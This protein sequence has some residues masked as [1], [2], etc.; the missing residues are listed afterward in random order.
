MIVRPRP[1]AHQLIYIVRGSVVRRIA[2]KVLLIAALSTAVV[3]FYQSNNLQFLNAGLG[4]FSILGLALSVFLGFRNNAC[5]DRWWEA[6][7][8]WGDLIVHSRSFARE[9]AALYPQ[10]ELRQAM[11]RRMIAYAHA[12]AAR[13][14]D[15]SEADAARPWLLPA[16]HA[17]LTHAR[18]VPNALLCM[19][20]D[21]LA[22]LYRQHQLS[23]I[24]YQTF[25]NKLAA[26]AVIQGACERIKTTPTPFA[27]SLLLRR[28]AWLFCLLLP[29]SLA[30]SL[31]MLAPLIVAAIAYTFFGLDYLGDELEEPFGLMDNDLPLNALVRGIEVDMLESLG[32]K[33]LPPYLQPVDYL[34]Q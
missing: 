26:V 6:R 27:Y 12:L 10:L 1:R 3:L 11:V 21:E 25:G 7:K 28:T 29:F 5:Y 9:L 4:T 24:L 33:E 22:K 19:Q 14:R 34:L 13:L 8:H 20:S 15:Q 2:W 23:D 17:L 31:G 30:P 32:E 16:E 18:N